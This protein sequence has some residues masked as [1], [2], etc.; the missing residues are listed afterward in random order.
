MSAY[1]AITFDVEADCP[2]VSDTYHGVHKGLPQLLDLLDSLEIHATFFVTGDIVQRFP[3]IVHDIASKHEVASHGLT[4]QALDSTSSDM[5]KELLTSKQLLEEVTGQEVLG[6]RAPRLRICP[7]LFSQLESA[8]YQ[9]DSSVSWWLP[10][11]RWFDSIQTKIV[12]F[13]PLLPN[14]LL[15]FPGGTR[16]FQ[17]V[18]LHRKPPAVLFFHPS[19]A[20]PMAPLLKQSGIDTTGLFWRPDRWINTGNGFSNRL[21][22]VL[23]YLKEHDFV[24]KPL[25]DMSK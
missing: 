17:R 13:Y 15:R 24:F 7:E 21:E 2:G 19:E 16:L 14:V 18:V 9:Y 5:R 22:Q 23:N 25:K 1:A 6:F 3:Q 12:E 4:H 8:G 11:H 10:K 20:V